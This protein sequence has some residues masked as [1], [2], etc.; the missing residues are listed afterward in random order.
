MEIRKIKSAK[1]ASNKFSTEIMVAE[2][3]NKWAFYEEG[4]GYIAY[5]CDRDK[6]GFLI[7]YSPLGGRKTLEEILNA[8]GFLNMN[9]IEYV[10]PIA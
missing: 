5:S 6:F 9:G 3:K 4:K 10:N 7:P 1:F 8:G 2:V